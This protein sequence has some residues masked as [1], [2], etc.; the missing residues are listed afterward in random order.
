[1]TVVNERMAELFDAAA[2]AYE[3]HMTRAEYFASDWIAKHTQDVEG[4]GRCDV[5]D[6]ACGT[7][8]SVKAICAQRSGVHAVGVDVSP[9]MLEQAR[10]SGLYERLFTHDLNDGLP[11]IAS[12]SFDLVVGFGVLE[13]LPDVRAC[14]AE[15]SRVLK[16]NGVLWASFRRFE[17]ED[18][19]SPPRH[20]II[21][22]IESHGYPADEISQMIQKLGMRMLGLSAVRGYITRAGFACPFYVA[23]AR[24]G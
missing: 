24:K 8:L 21:Q 3:G 4:L 14:L 11:D 20:V 16:D 23:R 15:C 10:Q 17:P 9:K 1:M 7:G 12:S 22:G 18:E 19:G 13:F 6:L 5:L 2:S